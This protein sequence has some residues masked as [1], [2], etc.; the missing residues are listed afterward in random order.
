MHGDF[1][2]LDETAHQ[3]GRF[4]NAYVTL[5]ATASLLAKAPER[6]SLIVAALLAMGAEDRILWGTG[7]ALAHP[8][9]LLERFWN[10]E[11]SPEILAMTGSPPLTKDIKRKILG[12]NA[13]R[14][15]DI[16]LGDLR[17]LAAAED[18]DRRRAARAVVGR[19]DR[20]HERRAEATDQHAAQPDRRSLQRGGG[21]AGG[22][23][24]DGPDPEA[25]GRRRRG[26]G[27][28]ARQ[29]PELHDG[30]GLPRPGPASS[31]RRCRA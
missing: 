29:A 21:S 25:R 7:A 19:E 8:Q 9:P 17:S 22:A 3:V 13:A 31:P 20:R 6:F 27:R 18:L 5:E 2:F 16:D 26:H 14:L 15:H 24:R 1:A 28:G 30:T 12:E 4:P 23:R 10:L 11:F